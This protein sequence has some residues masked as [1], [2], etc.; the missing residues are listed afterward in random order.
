MNTVRLFG[1][2]C[3]RRLTRRS[4]YHSANNLKYQPC[5]CQDFEWTVHPQLPDKNRNKQSISLRVT[6]WRQ[7][8]KVSGASLSVITNQRRSMMTGPV[9]IPGPFGIFLGKEKAHGELIAERRLVFVYHS[10]WAKNSR[11]R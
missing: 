3:C 9:G 6:A 5:G 8:G 4:C 1:Q 11:L 7:W 10:N 2:Q